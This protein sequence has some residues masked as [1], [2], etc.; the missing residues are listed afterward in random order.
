M[1]IYQFT[2]NVAVKQLTVF[3]VV[4]L[5][6]TGQ[7]Q[8]YAQS[9]QVKPVSLVFK[10]HLLDSVFV[11][12][13]VAV[14]DVNKDGK[15]DVLAG[16]FWYEAPSWKKHRLHAD[17]LNAIR[18]YCT[19]FINFSLDVNADGWID[20]IRF[21]QPGAGCTWYENPGKKKGLWPRHLILATAGIESPAFV[22]VDGDGRKDII[23]NDINLKQVIWLK[24]P[25]AKAD[26]VW[27]RFIIS[28]EPGRATHQ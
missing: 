9:Q 11:S 2:K 13:G 25:V 26:T 3:L 24:S 5:F 6:C 16:T 22:D 8:C 28:R 10:K 14:G 17:T 12:E 27:Q 1:N 23:C 18:G 21:D 4:V 15:T 20:L 7:S 19:S